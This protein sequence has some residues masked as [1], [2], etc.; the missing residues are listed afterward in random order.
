MNARHEDLPLDP[1]EML[2]IA[3]DSQRTAIARLTPDDRLLYLVWGVAWLVAFL[4]RWATSGDDPL[5]D[6]PTAGGVIYGVALATGAAITG[7]H[8]HRRVRG[9]GGATARAGQ[10]WGATWMCAFGAYPF[11]LGGIDRAH[12]SDA[13]IGVVAPVLAVFIVG[14]MYMVGGALWDD[15]IGFVTGGWTIAMA[16]TAAIVGANGHLVVL[17][18][19]GGGGFVVAAAAAHRRMTAL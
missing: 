9:I 3:D 11:I 17:G 15:S 7:I 14:L 6:A 19:G 1:V 4:V 2:A 8:I 16:A 13:L 18:L 5:V 12:G 10:R